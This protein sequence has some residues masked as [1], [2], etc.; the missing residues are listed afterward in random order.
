MTPRVVAMAADIPGARRIITLEGRCVGVLTTTARSMFYA[1][2]ARAR[3]GGCAS[4][5]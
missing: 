5:T 4:A 3:A 1:I 2:A